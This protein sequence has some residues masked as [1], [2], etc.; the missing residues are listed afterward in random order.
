[1]LPEDFEDYN[2][3]L[4]KNDPAV[5]DNIPNDTLA[6]PQKQGYVNDFEKIFTEAERSN[7]DS[8]LGNYK[9]ALHY[10]FYLVTMDSIERYDSSEYAYDNLLRAWNTSEKAYNRSMIIMFSL[11]N[12][13]IAIVR[14]NDAEAAITD[15]ET[16]IILER[17]K[18]LL[19]EKK[20]YQ[21]MLKVADASAKEI[22]EIRKAR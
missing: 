5:S 4:R 2:K 22:E 15:E 21:A 11:A 3:L 10:N 16:A 1:M 9:A 7:L 8:A 19:A 6:F 13:E 17:V 12:R 18:P 20:Y 14:G